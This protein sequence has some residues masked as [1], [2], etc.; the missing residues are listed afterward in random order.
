MPGWFWPVALVAAFLLAGPARAQD[1]RTDSALAIVPA[2]A[3][4]FNSTLRNKEQIDAVYKS[5]AY[6]KFRELQGVKDGLKM[7]H[8]EMKKE[9]NP[10]GVI[11]K[12][13]EQKENKELLDLL[14]DAV[15]HEIFCYGGAGWGDLVTAALK[16]NNSQSMAPLEAALTGSD[17]SKAG[18]RAILLSL[19]RDRKLLKFPDLVF[20]FKVS[21]PKKVQAQLERLEKLVVKALEGGP[22]L[23]KGKFK[24][25]E[26]GN[27]AL[28]LDGSMLPWDDI[29]VKDYEEKGG[30]FNDL[31]K[32]LK[33]LKGAISLSVKGD[34]LLV[35][36]TTSPADLDKLDKSGKKLATHPDLKPVG[37]HAK[38]PITSLGYTS[39]EF[40]R[41]LMSGSDLTQ[42]VAA[43][44]RM[45]NKTEEIPAAR[46]KAIEKDIDELS[47]EMKKWAPDPTS[48][49]SLEYLVSD[50]Y[51]GYSYV[52]GAGVEAEGGETAH[53]R[54]LR[55]QPDLRG[56][57]GHARR[58]DRVQGAG[59][60]AADRLRA[61][62]RH[63]H[64]QGRR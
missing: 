18:I 27:L 6:K 29:N 31:M 35:S 15:S 34:Y 53:P 16:A 20:G 4:F 62:G 49:V 63:L 47:A 48:S 3:A 38:E 28:H 40:N 9:G 2:D 64:G 50:G 33:A 26:N 11:H 14:V 24:K 30:E 43:L 55:R 44:K 60:V 46:K 42:T 22:P 51:E 57:G 52:M 21:D 61:P 12:A 25:D 23:L 10:L 13:L 17:P 56:R 36:F 45:L 7:L 58:W 54:P 59:E 1:V 5:N 32:H 41:A 19:Q 37:K 39:K 8:E